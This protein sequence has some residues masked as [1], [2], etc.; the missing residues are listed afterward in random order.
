[1]KR[2]QKVWLGMVLIAGVAGFTATAPSVSAGNV[3]IHIGVGEPVS[4]PI[5]Y[6]Y[7]YYPEEEVYF[8]P[9][10]RVYWWTDG[11]GWY[12]GPRVPA[13]I[14]LGASVNLDVDAPE[15]WHHHRLIIERFPRHHHRDRD[16]EHDRDDHDHDRH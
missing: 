7:V 14:R 15:P 11:T 12:S 16:R 3:V 9:E 13:S 2:L 4:R 5:V 1:M 6:H 10:T 8:V